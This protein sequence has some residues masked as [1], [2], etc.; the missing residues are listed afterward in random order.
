MFCPECGKSNPDGLK[1]CQYCN[2]ELIDNSAERMQSPAF[3]TYVSKVKNVDYKSVAEKIKT[4]KKII[5]PVAVVL[6]LVVGFVVL[7]S[8]FSSPERLVKSYFESY[9]QQDYAKMYSY[10]DVKEDEFINKEAFQK[11][12]K[13]STELDASRISNYTVNPVGMN[14][15]SKSESKPQGWVIEETKKSDKSSSDNKLSKEYE[16]T[17][18]LDG[19]GTEYKKIVSLVKQSGKS[20]LFFDK[21]K[22]ALK[23]SVQNDYII[24]VPKGI[25]LSID[26][27]SLQ[28][29]AVTEKP[30]LYEYKINSIF[31]G[32]HTYSV[33]GD[34]INGFEQ[35]F[36]VY[37]NGTDSESE[38]A[39]TDNYG[40]DLSIEKFELKKETVDSL[41]KNSQTVVNNIY[42]G[43]IS[44]KKANELGIQVTKSYTESFNNMYNTIVSRKKHENG[45]GLK[46][47]S[48][49]DFKTQDSQFRT[50]NGFE[51]EMDIDFNVKSTQTYMSLDS[52]EESD[53]EGT[54]SAY[55]TYRFEDNAWKISEL[56]LNV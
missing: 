26:G 16:I 4:K 40:Y 24:R 41:T 29:T 17:Y 8:I 22:I 50:N 43:V 28:G 6:V 47:I 35:L 46:S 49:S 10:L 21:Y 15:G 31:L 7:G 45:T 34:F 20:W 55:I 32:E 27:I 33:S 36:Y 30:N 48:F 54:G 12:M 18:L 38:Y 52:L 42:Q 53:Y 9:M 11:Y 1:N 23:D 19:D 5:I 44:G 25:S 13:T 14:T 39:R 56:G 3:D 51:Y 2:A 37:E